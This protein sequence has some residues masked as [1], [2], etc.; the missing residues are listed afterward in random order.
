LEIEVETSKPMSSE[1]KTE[2]PIE[3]VATAFAGKDTEQKPQQHQQRK[4]KKRKEGKENDLGEAKEEGAMDQD[5]KP[6]GSD[7]GTAFAGEEFSKFVNERGVQHI[8]TVVKNIS[9]QQP[10]WKQRFDRCGTC[11]TCSRS[12]PQ[13]GYKVP[14]PLCR[15]RGLG[16]QSVHHLHHGF[17]AV[18]V[19]IG[20]TNRKMNI[21]RLGQTRSQERPKFGVRGSC[22][23]WLK[24]YQVV[25]LKAQ[26]L[27]HIFIQYTQTT[28][29]T[30]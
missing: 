23:D 24:H 21:C 20:K 29:L 14:T 27:D 3:R 22:F 19:L 7:R 12:K 28:S 1:I 6:T 11:A 5:Q 16:E 25:F 26:S 18:F 2:E 10:K 15:K 8:K 4:A 17:S 9:E 30:T 13:T